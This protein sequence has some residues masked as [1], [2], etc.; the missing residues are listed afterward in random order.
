MHTVVRFIAGWAMLVGLVG[1][2]L[3][4]FLTGISMIRGIAIILA[5]GLAAIVERLDIIVSE[6]RGG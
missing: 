5:I 6:L 4:V 2:L 1:L 3:M